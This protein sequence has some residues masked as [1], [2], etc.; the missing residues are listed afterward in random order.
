MF[1][2][3]QAVLGSVFAE[4]SEDFA[5][6]LTDSAESDEEAN[7]HSECFS[8]SDGGGFSDGDGR[9]GWKSIGSATQVKPSSFRL[10][11]SS[12]VQIVSI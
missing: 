4:R 9:T 1:F 2:C 5:M 11:V 12:Y 10:C 3:L 7:R 8:F 6:D